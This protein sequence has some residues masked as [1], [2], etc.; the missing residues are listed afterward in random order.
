MVNY[1]IFTMH[2]MNKKIQYYMQQNIIIVKCTLTWLF[3]SL[4]SPRISSVQT[5]HAEY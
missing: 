2:P 5:R 3:L 1:V 4:V